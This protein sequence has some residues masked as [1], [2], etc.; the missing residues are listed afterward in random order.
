MDDR[1]EYKD[2]QILETYD[3]SLYNSN[4]RDR[5]EL[6][7]PCKRFSLICHFF[8]T[9]RP[10]PSDVVLQCLL[11]VAQMIPLQAMQ[12]NPFTQIIAANVMFFCH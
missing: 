6:S 2:F 10:P 12:Y 9:D 3:H 7:K 8:K 1:S 4:D 11:L 5:C